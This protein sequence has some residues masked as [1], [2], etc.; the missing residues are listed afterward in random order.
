MRLTIT[1]LAKGG[2]GVARADID[3]RGRVVLVARTAPGDVVDAVVSRTGQALRGEV[4][5]IVV[6]SPDRITPPCP[7]AERCGGCDLMHL[8]IDAQRAARARIVRELIGVPDEV[9]WRQH[10]APQVLQYRTRMRL[11]VEARHGRTVVGFRRARSHDIVQVDR[12]V[13]C[14][15]VIDEA[16]VRMAPWLSSCTGRGEIGISLGAARRPA[17]HLA[18]DG[19]LSPS[20]F[21]EAEARVRQG[22]WAGVQV[23]LAGATQPA[24]IGDPRSVTTAMDGAT[25]V[26]PAGGFTQAYDAMNLRLAKQVVQSAA[27]AG[28]KTL[29]LF[30]GSGNFTV[31]LAAQTDALETVESEPAAAEASRSNLTARGLVA[32]VRCGDADGFEVR[33]DVRVVVLDPPRSG[34]PGASARIAASR[35]RRVVMVSCD[36]ATLGRDLRTLTERGPF[37]VASVDLFE[38]FPHT[39][40]VETLVVLDRARKG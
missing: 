13:V 17:I 39:S 31:G 14:S 22:E 40:H 19:Q 37:S 6:P 30:A 4:A 26:A 15:E 5:T 20:V 7:H 9:A 21:S 16:R 33:D 35:T 25:L 23:A 10:D 32:R 11:A 28:R 18:W 29:E 34:A 38:M 2:E 1:S 27:C 3:G 12:C 24:V 8:T 36:P